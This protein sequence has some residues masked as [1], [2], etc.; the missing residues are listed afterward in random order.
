MKR[1]KRIWRRSV[2][3]QP[4]PLTFWALFILLFSAGL[5]ISTA[6]YDTPTMAAAPMVFQASQSQMQ[7][8]VDQADPAQTPPDPTDDGALEEDIDATDEAEALADTP[9]TRY[10]LYLPLLFQTASNGADTDADDSAMRSIDTAPSFVFEKR[11]TSSSDDGEERNGGS[12]SLSSSDLELVYDGS[13]SQVVAVRFTSVTLPKGAT[14]NNAY[15]QFGVD[16]VST[17]AA[18]LTIQGEATD[19]AAIL[20]T[21]TFSISS[22]NRTAAAVRWQPA[23]WPTVGES[24]VNQRTPNIATLFQEIISRPGWSSGN[25]VVILFRGSGRRTAYAY[26]KTTSGAPLL[27]VE[28]TTAPVNQPPM[29]NAGADQTIT[30]PATAT[31]AGSATDDGLP[32]SNLTVVWSKVSGPGAV[33]FATPNAVN[34]TA[35]FAT[36]GAYLLRLTA[37]D[38]QLTSTDEL[39]VIVLPAATPS[40]L[41]KRVAI[42]QDDAEELSDGRVLLGTS[43]L[44]LVMAGTISQTVGLRFPDI[45]IPQGA[46]I[47]NAYLQFH[48][49]RASA[50]AT[51]LTIQGE[52][53]D[54][55]PAMRTTLFNISRRNRTAT[56][57][58]WQPAPWRTVGENGVNQRT[59]NLAALLQ[60]MISRPGWRSGNALLFLVTGNGRRIAYAYEAARESAPL[61][62]I[63]YTT[64][65]ENQP[66][67]VN[68]GADQTITLPAAATLNGSATDDG[69]P[70]N[71]LTFAWSKVDGPGEV[72]FATPN[73]PTTT[74]TFAAAGSYLLRLTVTDGQLSSVDEVQVTVNP[75]AAVTFAGAGDIA[76]CSQ[77]FD[78][79]TALL[80]D[81]IPGTVFT[82]GDNVYSDGSA[83]E[84]AQCYEPS[85]GRH[86][87]RT[88]PASGNHDYHIPDAA[89]Y[90]AYF[91]A[92]AGEP[93]KGY[94]SYNLGEWHIIVLN[95]ECS[96][97][98]GC[99][100]SSPQ[101]QW[102]QADLA[103]NPHTC[104][105]AIWHKPRFSS[106][107]RGGSTAFNDF[108]R[109]LYNAGADVVLNGHD[110]FYERFGKQT[111]TGAADPVYG[112]RQ[113]IVG[114]GGAGLYAFGATVQPNSE[115]RNNTTYGVLKLTLYPTSY[116][117][118][119]V[120]IAG[121]SYTDS[122]S[123]A[124]STGRP[125][126]VNILATGDT[127]QATEVSEQ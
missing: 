57:V 83:L 72:R 44:Q 39:T 110:H 73:A 24:G 31:L 28:Y 89:D 116:D 1:F 71:L 54:N 35:S 94:Y 96:D 86:K 40:V 36:A 61:L 38:G 9:A 15:L 107:T 120:P 88:R 80:L 41:T 76:T 29:V 55:A 81:Q 70:I 62:Y 105:L 124:C 119:F 53:V 43:A 126:T 23:P 67:A 69:R 2:H 8:T 22:R 3:A 65:P 121:Q 99:T 112:L 97:V 47:R 115:A 118:E 79:A 42:R 122:G 34:T 48:T 91:G 114:T 46:T 27:R 92:A 106:G 13:T 77:P 93:G 33:N 108:W 7:Q 14:I 104:T 117:W 68:A 59:P 95:S 127:T 90:F 78:E 20:T 102:L 50:T 17:D 63:E 98:G 51:I 64:E 103:A 84:F 16:E 37:S 21:A 85:W 52:A 111:V 11:V 18:D 100:A 25:A 60:E 19:N 10:D 49:Y 123:T 58:R 6:A 30:L 87:A 74:V 56:A 82:L 45:V 125:S 5:A 66:P 12:I 101:G 32:T 109:L 26:D 4:R 75:A 113:F